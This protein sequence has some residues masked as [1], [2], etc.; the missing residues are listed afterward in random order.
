MAQ[1]KA[2]QCTQIPPIPAHRLNDKCERALHPLHL[3]CSSSSLKI[4]IYSELAAK[5]VEW[6]TDI[7]S[8]LSVLGPHSSRLQEVN[9][10][11]LRKAV[12]CCK[13]P[14][15]AFWT[16]SH[17]LLYAFLTPDWN[18]DGSAVW[19][20]ESYLCVRGQPN[21]LSKLDKVYGNVVQCFN[22]LCN[23]ATAGDSV[24]VQ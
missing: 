13:D 10:K 23:L 2:H 3:Q 20:W 5:R 9:F 4:G 15:L 18:I 21:S 22:S 19:Q 11:D 8:S 6:L 17:H 1:V 14:R 24:A 7:T 16:S 12:F